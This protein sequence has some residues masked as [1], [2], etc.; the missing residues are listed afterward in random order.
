[1]LESGEMSDCVI[2]VQEEQNGGQQEKKKVF[3]CIL[4]YE[5]TIIRVNN[6]KGVNWPSDPILMGRQ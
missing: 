4:L 6:K 5:I 2:E 1:M 3:Y